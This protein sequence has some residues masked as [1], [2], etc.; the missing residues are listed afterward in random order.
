MDMKSIKSKSL[1]SDGKEVSLA[2][3]KSSMK[4]D[5]PILSERIRNAGAIL[6]ENTIGKQRMM[7]FQMPTE[8]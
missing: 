1:F 4:K 3:L 6:S 8:L 2:L 5:L 7:F